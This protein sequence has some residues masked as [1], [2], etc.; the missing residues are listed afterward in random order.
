[1]VARGGDRAR[2]RGQR[3]G[4]RPWLRRLVEK[5][6]VAFPSR[7]GLDWER[8]GERIANRDFRAQDGRL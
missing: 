3:R 1:V 6:V 5:L 4:Y 2:R 8:V 7:D